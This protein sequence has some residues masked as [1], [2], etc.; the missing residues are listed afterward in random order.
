MPRSGISGGLS[1]IPNIPGQVDRRDLLKHEGKPLVAV[2]PATPSTNNNAANSCVD[3]SE[4][5]PVSAHHSLDIVIYRPR[6]ANN[7]IGIG[8]GG[9]CVVVGGQW[10]PPASR[11]RAAFLVLVVLGGESSPASAALFDLAS[12]ALNAVA[13]R[14]RCRLIV[15]R[16]PFLLPGACGG[17]CRLIIG[18]PEPP[19]P[20][21]QNWRLP[22]GDSVRITRRSIATSPSSVRCGRCE[23]SDVIV[24][25]CGPCVCDR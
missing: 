8:G 11:R 4:F 9:S 13:D 17:R 24:C 12:S 1:P 18:G 20:S 25:C 10:L 6:V 21:G 7:N 14:H 19:P 23:W 5:L 2:T 16:R 3:P 15:E 22:G